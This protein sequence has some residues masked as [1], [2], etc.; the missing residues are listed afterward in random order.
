MIPKH[1][2][3]DGVEFVPL[4]MVAKTEEGS[5]ERAL[6]RSMISGYYTYLTCHVEGNPILWPADHCPGNCSAHQLYHLAIQ[7]LGGVPKSE[8]EPLIEERLKAMYET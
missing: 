5:I 1:V 2:T 7:V 6:L 3:I 4:S 8:A